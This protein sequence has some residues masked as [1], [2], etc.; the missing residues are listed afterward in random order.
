MT[1]PPPD[2]L[3][4][5]PRSLW[6]D[7]PR[8]QAQQRGTLLLEFRMEIGRGRGWLLLHWPRTCGC[9]QEE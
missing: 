3:E 7:P 9:D 6:R 5:W 8:E 2:A 1:A 4:L